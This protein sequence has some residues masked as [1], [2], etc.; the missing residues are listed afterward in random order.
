MES[1]SR[2]IAENHAGV[3][4]SLNEFAR[5]LALKLESGEISPDSSMKLRL[6]DLFVAAACYHGDTCAL[7]YIEKAVLAKLGPTLTRGGNSSADVDDA[8]QVLRERL[9][10]GNKARPAK[11]SEY[12]GMGRLF[13]WARIAA[14]RI[15]Q[16]RSRKTRREVQV[17]PDRLWDTLL[18]TGDVEVEHLKKIYQDSFRRALALAVDDL[19]SRERVLLWQHAVKCV[20]SEQ[21]GA[22]Y[23]VHR[24]TVSRWIFAAQETLLKGTRQQLTQELKLSPGEL[25]SVLRLIQS[26]FETGIGDLLT[27]NAK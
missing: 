15:L 18:P 11:I 22:L 20:S 27:A 19:S 14:I 24:T 16:N 17:D 3:V 1:G 10:V 23:Q 8:L 2:D 13:S 6:G 12:N 4:F 26:Q 5:Y 21:L 25:D 9:F 7:D